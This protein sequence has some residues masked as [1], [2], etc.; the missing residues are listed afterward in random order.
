MSARRTRASNRDQHP[1]EI[2][3]LADLEAAE[4][5]SEA[6]PTPKRRTAGEVAAAKKAQQEAKDVTETAKQVALEKVARVQL[7]MKHADITAMTA[8]ASLPPKFRTKG[9]AASATVPKL[10]GALFPPAPIMYVY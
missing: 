5:D 9:L 2:Q 10:G 3:I 1:G 6:R 8:P 7:N 4:E